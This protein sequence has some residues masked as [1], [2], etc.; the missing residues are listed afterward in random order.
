MTTFT[1]PPTHLPYF[2]PTAIKMSRKLITCSAREIICFSQYR[3]RGVTLN[4]HDHSCCPLK[5]DTMAGVSLTVTDSIITGL[6]SSYYFYF[7]LYL[8]RRTCQS[9][10][11]ASF[12]MTRPSCAQPPPRVSPGL[13]WTPAHARTHACM[14]AR[15]D[16]H[17]ETRSWWET[18][19]VEEMAIIKEIGA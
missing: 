9:P 18:D 2:P 1:H 13:W 16:R 17:W 14:H 5:W 12:L 3:E 19:T 11:A 10:R 8:C 6:A 7:I 4:F 15:T